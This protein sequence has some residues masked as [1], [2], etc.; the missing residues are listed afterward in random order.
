LKVKLDPQ[1]PKA[2]WEPIRFPAFS[3]PSP[4]LVTLMALSLAFLA[5]LK[6][7]APVMLLA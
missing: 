4:T 5:L 2:A 7:L 3:A 1:R 6:Y